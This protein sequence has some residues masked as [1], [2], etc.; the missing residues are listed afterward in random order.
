MNVLHVKRMLYY[1]RG[2]FFG[3]ELYVRH[4]WC[5]IIQNTHNS[6]L[7][8]RHF[9]RAFDHNLQTI[10]HILAFYVYIPNDFAIIGDVAS[11]L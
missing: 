11:R 4:D 8:S 1:R 5:V 2:A 6:H 3:L 7:L 9:V 10:G